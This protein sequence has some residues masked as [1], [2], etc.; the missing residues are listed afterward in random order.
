MPR[1]QTMP[2]DD[3][4][5]YRAAQDG[6]LTSYG[7]VDRNAGVVHIPIDRAIE[8][9][10]ERAATIADPNATAAAPVA[11]P[12]PPTGAPTAPQPTPAP[13]AAAGH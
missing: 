7:W 12:A 9:M 8:L 5:R 13:P 10:A 4:T 3:L 6:K 2:G 11:A 1:L